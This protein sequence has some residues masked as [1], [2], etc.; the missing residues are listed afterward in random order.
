VQC[1]LC[2]LIL[3]T[4]RDGGVVAVCGRWHAARTKTRL[5]TTRTIESVVV[6]VVVVAAAGE[7]ELGK[8]GSVWRHVDDT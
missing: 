3:L 2:F 4:P 7:R 6:V 5:H 8:S 1:R